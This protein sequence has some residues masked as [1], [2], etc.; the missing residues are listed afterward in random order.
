VW[1][2]K[3]VFEHVNKGSDSVMLLELFDHDMI[4]ADDEMAQIVLPINTLPQARPG[5]RRANP[6][7]HPWWGCVEAEF[8]L[9]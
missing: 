6:K 9:P 8:S 7:D 4:G 1:E 2:E 5:D 3:F